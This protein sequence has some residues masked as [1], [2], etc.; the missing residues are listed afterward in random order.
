MQRISTRFSYQLQMS[1]SLSLFLSLL[2]LATFDRL[3]YPGLEHL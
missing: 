3:H 1:Q 2:P